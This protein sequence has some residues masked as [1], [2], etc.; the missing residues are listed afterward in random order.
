MR[1]FTYQN[2]SESIVLN[3]NLQNENSIDGVFRSEFDVISPVFEISSQT[4]P[5]FNYIFIPDFARYYYVD[6]IQNLLNG[7]WSISCSVDVL[8]SFR[9][10]ILQQK[11]IIARQE[12]LYNLYLD[13]EKLITTCRRR[14]WTKAFPTRVNPASSGGSSFV[15]TVAGGAETSTE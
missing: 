6:N 8:M 4:L 14:I 10:T 5:N 1:I 12:N 15:L 9:K 11:A 3:K 13:D 2:R 7:L